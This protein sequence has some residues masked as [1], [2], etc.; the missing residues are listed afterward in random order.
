MK[1]II[2]PGG[3]DSAALDAVFEA[4]V[5]A[6]RALPLVKTMLVPPAWSH[7]MAIPPAHRDLFGYCN[8]VMEPW[9]GPAALVATDSRWVVAG[10]DRN[11]LR[12]MRYSRTRDGLL[13]VGSETGM[14]P[15]VDNDVI[16]KGRVGPGECIAVD[17]T[18]GTFYGDARAQGPSG[19]AEALSAL[20]GEHHPSRRAGAAAPFAPTTYERAELKRRQNLYGLTIE[21]MELIL[22]PMV[23]DGKEAV[24][25]M[26]DD[27]PLAV[28]SKHYRGLHHFFRQQFSQVTNPPI[29][30][31]REWRVM[32]LKT[33]FGNLGNVYDEDP[34]QTAILQLESPVLTSTDVER[35]QWS[36]LPS[37][38]RIIDCTFE[39]Q[40]RRP[41]AG[42]ARPHPPGGRGGR[43]RRLRDPDPHRRECRARAGAD[44]DDP[45]HGRRAQP[46]G[47]PGPAQ[48]QL[49][50]GALGRVPRRPLFRGAD[51]RRGHR[52]ERLPRRGR[53]RRPASPAACSPA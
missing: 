40:C 15:L 30:P 17:M 27:T 32:S 38:L 49:P 21:D 7:R 29:D 8:C 43:P 51:R 44:A 50:R 25:S 42:R 14:V 3:S 6:G 41:A 39:R 2:Q 16:E 19:G 48:L 37:N 31:L 47:P 46:S 20:D 12:P 18:T 28:L 45:G 33:R 23:L 11:G 9:D 5:R 52:R 36:T 22:S 13:V 10:L 26:G 34:S 53:D 24:G 4:L 1:P 35:G